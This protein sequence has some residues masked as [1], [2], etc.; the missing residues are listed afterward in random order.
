MRLSIS[1]ARSMRSFWMGRLSRTV[2]AADMAWGAGC[3]NAGAAD[4]M[5]RATMVWNCIL[6]DWMGKLLESKR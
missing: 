2:E 3:A 1:A 6:K 5:M 4:I